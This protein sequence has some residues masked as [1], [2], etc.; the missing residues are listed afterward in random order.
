MKEKRS[1]YHGYEEFYVNGAE[2]KDLFEGR[3]YSTGRHHSVIRGI[4][5]PD[6][7]DLIGIRDS[8]KYRIFV[9]QHFCNVMRE[10]TDASVVFFAHTP[11]TKVKLSINLPVIP[12]EKTCSDCGAPMKI[13]TG[14]Y[15]EFLSCSRYPN[16][17]KSASIPIIGNYCDPS[18]KQ[19]ENIKKTFIV[20]DE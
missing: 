19:R 18:K 13:K 8:N 10:D 7:L 5:I 11:L 14:K 2:L 1:V 4:T 6:Y 3:Y 15:G 17:K 20:I 9:N 12:P 16:C